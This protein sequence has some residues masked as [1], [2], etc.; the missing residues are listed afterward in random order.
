MGHP[1]ICVWFGEER[2]ALMAGCELRTMAEF[3]FEIGLEE[4]A[5]RMIAGAQAELEQRVVGMLRREVLL[6]M[7]DEGLAVSFSTPRRL[8]VFVPKVFDK[9]S[10]TYTKTL[11]PAKSIAFKDG[12]PTPA[13]EAFARKNG[14]SVAEL[15]FEPTPKGDYLVAEVAR[16]GRSA[17]EVIAAEV[18]EEVAGI[19]WE[20]NMYWRGGEPEVCLC[21]CMR[22]PCHAV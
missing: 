7:Q 6:S 11:G 14:L 22:E 18:P 21:V 16:K 8:A 10:D 2:C 20:K 19:Y 1:G 12:Q 17:A 15:K 4:I 5:A 13:A 9:Q 3:L